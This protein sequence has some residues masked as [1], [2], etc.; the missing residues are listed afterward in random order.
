MKDYEYIVLLIVMFL[1]LV[2]LCVYV[3]YLEE[4]LKKQKK[5]LNMNVRISDSKMFREY[6]ELTKNILDDERI[7]LDT[8]KEYKERWEI[9]DKKY[10]S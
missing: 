2:G 9:I 10:K 1:F 5:A 4:A 6:L 7:P 8:K 3:V